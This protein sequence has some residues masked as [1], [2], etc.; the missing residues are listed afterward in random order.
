MSKN[1]PAPLNYADELD[2]PFARFLWLAESAAKD[3]Q[4][5]PQLEEAAQ[6][7]KAKTAQQAAEAAEAAGWDNV[8]QKPSPEDQITKVSTWMY[9]FDGFS[10][11]SRGSVSETV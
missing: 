8:Q 6:E 10:S 5:L 4:A 7:A 2:D 9:S 11:S 3:L 1:S